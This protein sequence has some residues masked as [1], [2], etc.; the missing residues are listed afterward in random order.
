MAR[1]RPTGRPCL[2]AQTT[3][4][5]TYPTAAGSFFA[6]Y[7]RSRSSAPRSK[8]AR[9]SSPRTVA[10]FFALTSASTVPP[11]GTTILVTFVGNRW[12]FRYDA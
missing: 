2:V 7:A 5:G 11:V 6:C 12:V 3:T 9:R 10:T 1:H 4:V 8:G